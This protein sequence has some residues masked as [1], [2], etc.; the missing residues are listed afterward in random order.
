[1]KASIA[2]RPSRS[3]PE[4]SGRAIMMTIASS[5]TVTVDP[6]TVDP[7]TGDPVTGD[8][9]AGDPVFESSAFMISP[10]G[11]RRGNGDRTCIR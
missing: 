1:A 10:S 7:V 4:V 11:L 8:P 5:V 6:V 3:R 2:A 9:V